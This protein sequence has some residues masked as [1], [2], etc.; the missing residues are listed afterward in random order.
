MCQHQ[1]VPHTGTN[2]VLVHE[3]FFLQCQNASN[4]SV[5]FYE[6]KA[7]NNICMYDCNL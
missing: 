6:T 4:L 3:F 7:L 5:Y 2:F 1:S